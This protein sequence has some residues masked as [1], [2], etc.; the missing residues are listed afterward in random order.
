MLSVEGVVHGLLQLQSGVLLVRRARLGLEHDALLGSLAVQ[1]LVADAVT[2]LP[3]A[4][5][6]VNALERN[7][8]QGVEL[9]V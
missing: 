7:L 2:V 1:L 8:V 4:A 9:I 3:V 5:T 6:I